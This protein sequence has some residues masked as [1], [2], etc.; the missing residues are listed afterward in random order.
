MNRNHRRHPRIAVD[1][2]IVVR[3]D[4]ALEST[5]ALDISSSGLRFRT[6]KSW[7][8][9]HH[10]TVT[11]CGVSNKA[12]A[13]GTIVR[14]DQ[15]VACVEFSGSPGEIVVRS[16]LIEEFQEWSSRLSKL[17]QTRDQRIPVYVHTGPSRPTTFSSFRAVLCDFDTVG[18]FLETRKRI[19]VGET[20][21]VLLRSGFTVD[22]SVQIQIRVVRSS[23]IGMGVSFLGPQSEKESFFNKLTRRG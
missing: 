7:R 1:M 15:G 6:T 17:D 21:R 2:P 22:R 18:G 11:L 8:V 10:V 16:G 5:Q 3:Q 9:G 4:T 14:A 12:S 23:K 20:A 13:Y 19:E